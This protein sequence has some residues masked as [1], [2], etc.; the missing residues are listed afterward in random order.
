MFCRVR[1]RTR[2]ENQQCDLG[3]SD[4]LRMAIQVQELVSFVVC[5]DKFIL[6]RE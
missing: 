5:I 6:M 1:R 3:L 4:Q 2:I